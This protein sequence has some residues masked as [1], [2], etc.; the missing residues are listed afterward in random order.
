MSDYQRPEKRGEDDCKWAALGD[1]QGDKLFLCFFPQNTGHCAHVGHPLQKEKQPC[2]YWQ[3][4]MIFHT[5]N[6][7]DL[8]REGT[9]RTEFRTSGRY[10]F[11]STSR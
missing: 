3:D 1:L 2:S 11:I 5:Q 6:H 7:K 9:L 10:K 8:L 4:E